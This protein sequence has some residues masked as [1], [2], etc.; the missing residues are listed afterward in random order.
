MIEIVRSSAR[1]GPRA[2]SAVNVRSPLASNSDGCRWFS[3]SVRSISRRRS[4]SIADEPARR[5]LETRLP[6]RQQTWKVLD[7]GERRF[8]L[9]EQF[10]ERVRGQCLG[11]FARE[12]RKRLMQDRAALRR[13]RIG[14]DLVERIEPQHMP[15][16]D[17]IGIADERLDF[18]DAEPR[19]PCSYGRSRLRPFD[20]R[21]RIWPFQCA[22]ERE[23]APAAIANGLPGVF[24]RDCLKPLQ[25][26]RGDRLDAVLFFARDTITSRALTA[27][28]KSCAVRPM[29]RSG[30]SSLSRRRIGRLS[31]ASAWV[32]GGHVPSLRPPSSTRS[33]SSKRASS[34][35]RMRMR[36]ARSKGGRTGGS[37][38]SSRA[39]LSA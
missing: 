23:I 3:A 32:S 37:P 27:W 33:L 18:S 13:P 34:G 38:E 4:N 2:R 21:L 10:V 12:L 8:A 35:P 28:A 30:R 1:S 7:A 19:G 17:R 31:Q 24:R 29:R 22:R 14:I 15:R 26:A 25:K 36:A 39:K 16:I 5:P 9:R 11:I 6:D 20:R